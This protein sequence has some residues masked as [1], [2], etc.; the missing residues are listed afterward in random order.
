MPWFKILASKYY[1]KERLF[2]FSYYKSILDFFAFLRYDQP[3]FCAAR[4]RTTGIVYSWY[5]TFRVWGQLS[6]KAEF[7]YRFRRFPIGYNCMISWNQI[8]SWSFNQYVKKMK[9]L[10]LVALLYYILFFNCKRTA[11]NL[12]FKSMANE[13][14]Q[15]ISY[16]TTEFL[17]C[18]TGV[19]V[20]YCNSLYRVI[21]RLEVGLMKSGQKI[22]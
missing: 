21:G 20:L 1:P 9:L 18:G 17:I 14:H 12:I 11:G 15:I 6:Y 8:T 13:H 16:N 5:I 7:L 22:Y 2:I 19:N 10:G 4:G 3:V